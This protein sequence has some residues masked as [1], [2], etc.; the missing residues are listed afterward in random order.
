MSVYLSIQIASYSARD[1]EL[2]TVQLQ[3]CD[4]SLHIESWYI[5]WWASSDTWYIYGK[6]YCL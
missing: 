6:K 3:Y 4:A 2:V 1:I 5:A